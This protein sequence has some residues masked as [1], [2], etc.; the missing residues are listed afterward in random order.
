MTQLTVSSRQLYAVPR[1]TSR[2]ACSQNARVS[3]KARAVQLSD[4]EELPPGVAESL[5][6]ARAFALQAAAVLAP[7]AGV[8]GLQ[9]APH[10]E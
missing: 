4:A 7:I 1:P 8:H 5:A 2:S 10:L 3:I 9:P 6:E